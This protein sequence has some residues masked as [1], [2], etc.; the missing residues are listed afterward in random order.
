MPASEIMPRFRADKLHSGKSGKIVTNPKQA[1]AI[2]LSYARKEG[3]DIPEV[4][5][6]HSKPK[7]RRG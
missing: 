5:K 3:H 1:V 2:E 4:P 7:R 6:R